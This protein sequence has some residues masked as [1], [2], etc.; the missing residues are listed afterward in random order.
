M[1]VTLTLG[2]CTVGPS[3]EA[4]APPSAQGYVQQNHAASSRDIG[5]HVSIGEALRKDWWASLQSPPLNQLVEQALTYNWSIE[6]ARASLAKEQET[7]KV[8]RG[9][10][11][12]TIDL[13]AGAERQKYGAFDQGSS[14]PVFSAYE[15]G[16][17]VSY[18]L[19]AFGVRRGQVELASANAEVQEEVLNAARLNIAGDTVL[20]ALQIA[21][22]RAQINVVTSVIASDQRNL[23]LVG[24]ACEVGVATQGDVT[25]AQSQLDHDR[26]LLPPLHQQL[27]LSED[28]LAVLV[29]QSPATWAAPD[30]N[31]EALTLVQD[32]PLVVPSELVRSR[33]DIR[34][35][36]ARLHA[37]SAAVGI[38]TADMYPHLTLS[39]GISQQ[40][41]FSGPA[42]MAWNLIGGLTAP[43]FNGGALSAHRR[44]MQDAYQ[45]AFAQYQQTVL[46]AF[47]Q[48][49]D[50]LHGLANSADALVTEQQAL[51]SASDALRLSRLG[52]SMGNTGVVQ[53]LDA[54]RLQQLAEIQLVQART[55]RY[56]QTVNLFLAVGGGITDPPLGSRGNSAAESDSAVLST[57]AANGSDQ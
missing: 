16:A 2:G 22:V 29:G 46:D 4:P 28:A 3:Y 42:S 26:T 56:V 11:F 50:H 34:A 54:Q 43:V 40:G 25:S 35:A 23:A 12:P 20:E 51:H 55:Q 24:K 53:V 49:A 10:L 52:Y 33:P 14:L 8:A 47:K 37:A 6:V 38:A 44:E 18:D 9:G 32:I 7:I 39:S 31:L 15:G 21:S 57:S 45:A 19:D 1:L 17:A 36:Q 30:F 5:Q 13:T 48:V 27:N 41:L